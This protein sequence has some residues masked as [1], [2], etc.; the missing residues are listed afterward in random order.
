MRLQNL[1]GWDILPS[2]P[3]ICFQEPQPRTLCVVISSAAN[4]FIAFY[5]SV[6]HNLYNH[7]GYSVS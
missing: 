6:L 7:K 4:I 2:M 1:F 3:G 5:F